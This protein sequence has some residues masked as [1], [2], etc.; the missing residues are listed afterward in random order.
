MVAAGKPPSV[1]ILSVRNACKRQRESDTRKNMA[2]KVG[3]CGNC[4]SPVWSDQEHVMW[5]GFV[6]IHEG[7]WD[8]SNDKT[9]EP[10]T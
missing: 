8:G 2:D 3:N 1:G 6:P 9:E 4:S 7:C 10:D 5:E